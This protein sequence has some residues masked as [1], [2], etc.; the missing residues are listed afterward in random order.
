M[1]SKEKDSFKNKTNYKNHPI[2]T[3]VSHQHL[4]LSVKQLSAIPSVWSRVAQ[5]REPGVVAHAPISALRRVRQKV[6]LRFTSA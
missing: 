5:Q 6:Q 2:Q 3:S 4:K 1:N